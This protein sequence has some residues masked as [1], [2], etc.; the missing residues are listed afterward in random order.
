M[1]LNLTVSNENYCATIIKVHSLVKLDGLDNLVAAPIFGFQALVS[2]D[3]EVDVL[4]LL[5]TAETQLS[6]EFC[7]ENNLYDKKELNKD[8]L[9]KGYVNSKRRVRAVKL[10][11]HNSS[12]LLMD[13]SAL[14]YLGIDLSALKEGD[15]FNEIN[16][17]EICRKYIIREPRVSKGPRAFT[18]RTRVNSKL[19]PEHIDTAHWGR[20][21][22]KVDD[23]TAVIISQ[24]IHGCLHHDTILDTLEFGPISIGKIVNEKI[25]CKVLCRNI[26]NN[27][28]I[29]ADIDEYFSK[30]DEDANWYEIELEGGNKVVI[31][32]NNPVWLPELKCYRRADLLEVG[33][34]LLANKP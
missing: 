12:A 28:D 19:I 32:G 11:G 1:S 20:N 27:E 31:T 14:S 24:K 10:R 33:D 2:K 8:P 21:S 25:K 7:V 13:L 30:E 26:I 23:D 9:K 4:A 17:V 3:Q 22:N 15:T 34:V 16:G 5:F 6:H 18:P 29:Y